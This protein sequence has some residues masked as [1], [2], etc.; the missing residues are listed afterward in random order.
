MNQR[1][2]FASGFLAGSLVGSIIG[3]VIGAV[4]AQRVG[5][6]AD[7]VDPRLNASPS[8]A[9]N[10]KGKRRQIKASDDAS[11]EAARRSL[12]DKIAQLNETI[13]EVRLTLGDV[14]GTPPNGNTER[15]L[16]RDL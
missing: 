6:A 12:E 16:S 15:S 4:V 5:T 2:G 7:Q 14:N 9:K 1:D 13:D 11:I 10:I 3:G 8:D